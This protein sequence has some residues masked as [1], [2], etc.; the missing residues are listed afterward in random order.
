MNKTYETNHPI[1]KKISIGDRFINNRG[2]LLEFFEYNE[3]SDRY[4]FIFKIINELPE[5]NPN[6]K[7]HIGFASVSY[8]RQLCYHTNPDDE[9][10]IYDIH[11]K[12]PN[13][14]DKIEL[15]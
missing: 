7:S 4:M 13:L 14:K 5:Y 3:D 12:Y 2:D 10:I 6:F 11:Y 8:S 15:I 9:T 1:I